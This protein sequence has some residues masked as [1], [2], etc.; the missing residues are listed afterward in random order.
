MFLDFGSN[1]VLER[2]A[3][4]L[5]YVLHRVRVSQCRPSGVVQNPAGRLPREMPLDKFSSRRR[6]S[7]FILDSSANQMI[8]GRSLRHPYTLSLSNCYSQIIL[9]LKG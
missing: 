6:A 3:F 1:S 5:K 2:V 7:N 8:N 9:L 4:G